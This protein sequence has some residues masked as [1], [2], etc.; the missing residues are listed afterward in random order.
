MGF[1]LTK[2][3]KLRIGR[4]KSSEMLHD[5]PRNSRPLRWKGYA[6]L[7]QRH[8]VTTQKTWIFIITAERTWNP[9][10]KKKKPWLPTLFSGMTYSEF[11]GKDSS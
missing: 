6:P 4:S 7:E 3:T 11:M 9:E 10:V 8:R 2:S 1:I 5:F